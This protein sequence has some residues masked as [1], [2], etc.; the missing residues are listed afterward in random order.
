MLHVSVGNV[1][2]YLN[3][4]V[5]IDRKLMVLS[6]FSNN[7]M[8][9]KGICKNID[10]Y[11]PVRI[12]SEDRICAAFGGGME[13]EHYHTKVSS[14]RENVYHSLSFSNLINQRYIFVCKERWQDDMYSY[15]MNQFEY[16][17][18]REWIP[19]ICQQAEKEELL[20]R[21]QLEIVGSGEVF[22][23]Y[24]A[25][26][27]TMTNEELRSILEIGLSS[28]NI[29]IVNEEQKS[30]VFKDMDDYFEKY[31]HT[32]VNNLERLLEPL[33]PME[34]KV[35]NLAFIEKSPFPQQAAIING[36]VKCLQNKDYVLLI[37]SMGAGKTLQ[38]MGVAEAYFNEKYLKANPDKSII[39]IYKDGNLVNYRVIIMC[40]PHLVEKWAQS[41]R[42][43]IPYAKVVILESLEQ[44]VALRKEGRKSKGKQFYVMSKDSGKLS[45]SYAPVP[46]QIKRKKPKV[47][48][49]V[50]C[51]NEFP[52]GEG[53]ICKCGCAEWILEEQKQEETGLVCTE[54]G[55]LLLPVD[56]RKAYDQE[57]GRYRVLLPEDFAQ[58]ST[59][60][61]FCR[62]CKTAL[63][64]PAC[65]NVDHRIMFHKPK[66]KQKKWKKIS[67]FT[68]KAKK[69]RKS[70]WVLSSRERQYKLLHDIDD[71][72]VEEMDY[73]GPRRFGLTRYIKKYLKGYFE[74]A[75]FDEVQ[76]YKAGNSAQGYAMHDLIKATK[77]HM[78]LTGTIAG[79]YAS[80][81]FYTLYRLDPRRMKSKGYDY[82]SKGERRFVEQ[83][84]TVETVY[85]VVENTHTHSLSRGHVVTPQRCLP[86]ISVLIFTEFLLDT[87]LFLDLS[88][89]SRYLPGLYEEVL[90]VPLES[91]IQS[92]YENVRRILKEEMTKG[93]DPLLM[94]SFL[95]FSL[96]YTDFPYDREP[97]KS[98]KTGEEVVSPRD[99]S[100][101][102]AKQ[103][104]LNKE[105]E[106]VNIINKE[107]SEG[108]NVFIY[109]EYTGDGEG[110]I[111][112]RLKEVIENHCKLR[113][114]EVVVLESSYPVAAKREMWMHQK[115]SEG[116]KIFITNAKCV[117][118]GLDFA[119]TYK[120]KKYNYP[121]IIFYQTG[122]DM[123]KIWQASRRAYRLNQTEDCRTYFLVSEKTIQIDAVELVATKEVA[124][125][126]IQGQFSSEGLSTMARGV[127]SR[128]V[129]AQA[130]AEKSEQKERGLRKMMDVLNQRNNQGKGDVEYDKMLTFSELT[131]LK[132]VP[133]IEDVLSEY[134]WLAG[135]DILDLL[136]IGSSFAEEE[137]VIDIIDSM[138]HDEPAIT[139]IETKEQEEISGGGS[140]SDLEMLLDFLY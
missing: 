116:T 35:K 113:G 72:D 119:F 131:G 92:E 24:E 89:L 5:T 4:A 106:L 46:Y 87:A 70:V 39:D 130:V 31:G 55:E 58:Q 52:V 14:G 73:N 127:D 97:I 90:I 120:G 121:T 54:C 44:L 11:H 96:S 129:L 26:Y 23:K 140:K 128:V 104:L 65:E 80:D 114:H 71:G 50:K 134:E 32:L 62:C 107:Q 112:Y 135:E 69:A 34:N 136:D 110:T 111:T 57:N 109:C 126:A 101:L 53:E 124:T 100:Y 37:E 86:G 2:S 42:E 20:T 91:E 78:A 28:H 79:G 139:I 103:G 45:Y 137:P 95:Q 41:I 27:S 93:E 117:A 25:I 81:L 133:N 9:V 40:P 21:K 99:L 102:V 1:F 77:K 88:D 17:L 82:S 68:N 60:N 75:I 15:L 38:A 74:M 3:Y 30:L 51:G 61:R 76:E 123:I 13:M 29:C 49:C 56:S 108:R 8:S 84:G 83:Y 22:E 115:A 33:S 36:A 125:S 16:P 105:K 85:E 7:E 6:T 98:P 63:W 48:V 94:G 18:L 67:H 10:S 19:Y 64:T 59:M 66:P 138:V 12:I 43:E 132:E 47:P 122:Y 118:T